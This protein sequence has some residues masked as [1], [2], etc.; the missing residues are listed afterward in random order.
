MNAGYI[1]LNSMTING[2]Y[3]LT[4]QNNYFTTSARRDII[5]NIK[6]YSE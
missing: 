6:I 5:S 2:E 3:F 4:P 1:N